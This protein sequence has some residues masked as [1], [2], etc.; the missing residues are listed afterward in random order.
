MTDEKSIEYFKEQ[1]AMLK[2]DFKVA[3]KSGEKAK[4]DI[5]SRKAEHM[6]N[7][8]NAL[9]KNCSSNESAILI[10]SELPNRKGTPVYIK[11]NNRIDD[12]WFGWWDILDEVHENYIKTSYS[13]KLTRAEKGVSWE[14]FDSIVD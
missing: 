11:E 1:Y 10:W 13:D 6:F 8:L 5:I 14:I 4:A 9:R 7:A 2:S 12:E 3:I